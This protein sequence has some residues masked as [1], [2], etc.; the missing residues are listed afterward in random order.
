MGSCLDLEILDELVDIMGDDMGMLLN[1]YFSDSQTKLAELSQ[2]VI[3]TDQEKIFRMVHAL[4]GSSR[5]VGVVVFS[6]VCEKIEQLAR[7]GNLTENDFDIENLN[8]LHIQA[9]DELKQRY[10]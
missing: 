4:K 7:A 6:D 2:M 3:Q 9:T 10:L 1:S 8:Q 5:N